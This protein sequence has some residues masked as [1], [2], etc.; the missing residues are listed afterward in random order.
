M[1]ELI[2]GVVFVVGCVVAAVEWWKGPDIPS[3]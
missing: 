3:K 2:V 1:L